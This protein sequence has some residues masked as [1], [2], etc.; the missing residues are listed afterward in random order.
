METITGIVLAGGRSARM[1]ADKGLLSLNGRP[2][3]QHVLDPMAKICGRILLV[4][5][6]PAYGKFGC[7]LVKDEQDGYGPVMGI[8]SGLRRSQTEL[9]LVMSCDVPFVGLDL[10]NDLV[11]HSKGF[12]AVVACSKGK[13]HPL[14]AVYRRSCL[15]GFEK[16]VQEKE[17][18]MK[19]VLRLFKV[20]LY[21]EPDQDGKRLQ[22]MNT[23]ED[24]KAWS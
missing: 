14:V 4:T 7:E 3:V 2:M 22:N 6:N 15:S 16:A 23:K 9:N 19:T 5:Q 8:V 10:M 13:V 21:Q 17:H 12:D 18:R 20:F 1:G 11:R 24:L